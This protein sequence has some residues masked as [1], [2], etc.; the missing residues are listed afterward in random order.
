[1]KRT[2]L[3]PVSLFVTF[4]VIVGVLAIPVVLIL[5]TVSQMLGAVG[6][7]LFIAW[8]GAIA[9]TTLRG[10]IVPIV[11]SV[12]VGILFVATAFGLFGIIVLDELVLQPRTGDAAFDRPFPTRTFLRGPDQS[13]FVEDAQGVSLSGLYVVTPREG[14][15]IREYDSGL[16]RN[17]RSE[18]VVNG[19]SAPEPISLADTTAVRWRQTPPSLRA[20]V[21]DANRVY[22]RLRDRF[23][24]GFSLDFVLTIV[25]VAALLAMVWTPARITRWPLLNALFVFAYVRGV[26]ALPHGVER[27]AESI[28]MP[29]FLPTFVVNNIS[30]VVMALLSLVLL[31]IALVLPPM[32]EWRREVLGEGGPS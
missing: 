29:V 21:S 2:L 7:L 28:P 16:W 32:R 6:P 10:V 9:C 8:I 31:V 27:L 18:I 5:G 14:I 1:M 17:D 23:H 3:I 25:S 4:L 22:I 15:A 12:M 13:V 20:I 11:P 30:D 19:D 26:V 24:A